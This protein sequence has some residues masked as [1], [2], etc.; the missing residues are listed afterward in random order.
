MLYFPKSDYNDNCTLKP[1]VDILFILCEATDVCK[2]SVIVVIRL[3]EVFS[4]AT[5][6]SK[7]YVTSDSSFETEV[8]R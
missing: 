5:K 8:L 6:Y 3:V 1:K 7:N 4:N 2:R